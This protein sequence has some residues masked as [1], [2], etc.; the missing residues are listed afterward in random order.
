MPPKKS[1]K[2]NFANEKFSP[3]ELK[4]L[5]DLSSLADKNIVGCD[6]T[7]VGDY[8]TPIVAAAVYLEANQ[9]PELLQLGIKDTKE[10][11]DQKVLQLFE[12][13]KNKI[14]YRV[15]HFTQK[16]YNNLNKYLNAHELKMFLH[17]KSITQLEKQE[18]INEDFVLID[19][20]STA[21]AIQ[22]YYKNLQLSSSLQTDEITKPV[23]LSTKAENKHLAVACAAIVARQKFLTLMKEQEEACGMKF[24]LGTNQ[25]VEKVA[26]AFCQKFGRKNLYEVAKIKFQTTEKIDAVL[27]KE[28]QK[29]TK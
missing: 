25:E 7:G 13:I 12:Q 21:K 15:N 26:I 16:G 4:E 27:P 5:D 22:E 2:R 20:F 18:K 6:E 14:K 1:K 28:E 24:P 23:I 29:T 19:Q 8:L 3:L 9:I 11:S 10:L 17:L